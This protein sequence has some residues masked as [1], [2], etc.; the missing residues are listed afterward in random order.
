PALANMC[1]RLRGNLPRLPFGR[2]I[3]NQ[4]VHDV[5]PTAEETFTGTI[6]TSQPCMPCL[7]ASQQRMGAL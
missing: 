6:D 5:P 4:D 3:D 2:S 7:N 1:C